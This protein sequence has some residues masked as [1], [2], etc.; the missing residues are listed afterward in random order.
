MDML[1]RSYV[2]AFLITV[3]ILAGFHDG[4]WATKHYILN[5]DLQMPRLYFWLPMW[6]GI[7]IGFICTIGRDER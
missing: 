4:E 7:C 3:V 1:K 5:F 2:L 6:A